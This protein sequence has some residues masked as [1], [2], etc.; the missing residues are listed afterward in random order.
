[1]G[2]ITAEGLG[3]IYDIGLCWAPVDLNT[4]DGATGK[5]LAVMPGRG[6]SIVIIKA[7][8]TAA[9]DFTYTLKQHTA[10]T[11]GTSGNLTGI[12]HY[13][14]KSETALDN[15]ES[16]SIVSQTL[17]ATI[18]DAGGAGTSAESQQIVVIPVQDSLLTEGY[19]HISLDASA[20]V[21]NAQLAA[22]IYIVHS[23][24]YPRRP[25]RLFN[26]LRPG[27]ANA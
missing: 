8:G 15:D 2:S 21:A 10:Y 19:T 6:V 9:D 22:A 7:A 14:L 12:D 5:R 20:T 16:W 24:R 27:A 13:Y 23:L 17:A 3:R 4:A 26:L 11:G 1:M 18:P 25:D